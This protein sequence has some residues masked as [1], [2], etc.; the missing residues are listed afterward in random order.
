MFYK[1]KENIENKDK[2]AENPLLKKFREKY[3]WE[4][5]S[6]Y[7]K[8]PK[9]KILDS[10]FGN[11]S[12]M[13]KEERKKILDRLLITEEQK[14]FLLNTYDIDWLIVEDNKPLLLEEKS[15]SKFTVSRLTVVFFCGDIFSPTSSVADKVSR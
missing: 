8:D 3:R 14:E 10:L 7:Y 5:L 6:E 11:P 1:N 13:T 4:N 15:T 12:S 2:M 9:F